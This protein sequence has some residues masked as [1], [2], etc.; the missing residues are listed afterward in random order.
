LL[1]AAAEDLLGRNSECGRRLSRLSDEW[2]AEPIYFFLLACHHMEFQRFERA[3]G[4]LGRWPAG[5]PD[6]DRRP[7]YLEANLALDQGRVPD[8]PDPNPNDDAS[9]GAPESTHLGTRAWIFLTARAEILQGNHD[10]AW[11]IC[12]DL[13]TEGFVTEKVVKLQVEAASGAKTAV[14]EGWHPP[15]V[16]PDSC[17]PGVVHY[18]V[19]RDDGIRPTALLQKYNEVHPEQIRATWLR[20]AFWLDP[21]RNWIA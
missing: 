11:G 15:T 12:E 5:S 4:V 21:V 14:P 9:S 20:P 2:T 19:G 8:L 13:I 6:P 7:L 1:H 3:A 16:L 18:G 10:R 17:L